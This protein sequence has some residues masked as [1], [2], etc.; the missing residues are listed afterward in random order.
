MPEQCSLGLVRFEMPVRHS[1]GDGKFQT[2]PQGRDINL[3]VNNI[4]K[5]IRLDENMYSHE[6]NIT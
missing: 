6:S 4:F 1:N 5:A 3:G 2:G